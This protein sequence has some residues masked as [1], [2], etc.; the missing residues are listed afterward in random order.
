MTLPPTGPPWAPHLPPC[1]CIHSDA[2]LCSHGRTRTP[3]PDDPHQYDLCECPCHD[4]GDE[5]DE[6][7][8][9]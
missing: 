3:L 2:V 4:E 9:G 1:A 7:V 8:R 6:G 5:G